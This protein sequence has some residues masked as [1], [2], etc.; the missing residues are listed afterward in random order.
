ML[1]CK[2]SW[3]ADLTTDETVPDL[4]EDEYEDWSHLQLP[5]LHG[6]VNH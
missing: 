4:E 6:A 5:K 2:L 3:I 1:E